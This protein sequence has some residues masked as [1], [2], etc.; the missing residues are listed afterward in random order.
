[1]DNEKEKHANNIN[2]SISELLNSKTVLKRKKKTEED[3]NK[4]LF[5]NIVTALEK[6]N[7]RSELSLL[8]LNL[9]L[10]KY[11]EPFYTIIESLLELN[12]GKNAVDLIYFYIFDRVDEEGNNRMLIDE[13]GNEYILQNPGDLWEL[14]QIIN[15]TKKK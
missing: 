11:D 9:D 14:I 3:L 1:M 15:V 6:T 5:E 10:S 8:E 4:E 7:I 2:I 13:S 12:F